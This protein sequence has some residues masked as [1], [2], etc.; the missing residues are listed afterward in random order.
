[1]KLNKKLNYFYQIA[2]ISFTFYVAITV[3]LTNCPCCGIIIK[4]MQIGLGLLVM[5]LG[6]V[7][8]IYLKIGDNNEK[9]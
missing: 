4:F 6:M 9:T 5:I 1:M 7:A 2:V 3:I 8:C